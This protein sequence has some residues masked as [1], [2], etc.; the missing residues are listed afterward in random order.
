MD[1]D[2]PK[3][4]E[5]E[6]AALMA[7]STTVRK[8]RLEVGPTI[9]PKRRKQLKDL[10]V[11]VSAD[12][13]C[14][15]E[16]EQNFAA[17]YFNKLKEQL[18]PA[19]F[20]KVLELLSDFDG[21]SEGVINLF[22]DISSL[23]PPSLAKEFLCF[24]TPD[25]AHLC[26]KFMD[27]FILSKMIEFFRKFEICF[28]KQPQMVRKFYDVLCQ[29]A[30]SEDVSL[31]QVREA[32][33]PLLKTKNFLMEYFLQLFP[34]EKPSDSFVLDDY[35][36]IYLDGECGVEEE[37]RL[38]ETEESANCPCSCHPSHATH[39]QRCAVKYINGRVYIQTGKVLRSARV[40]FN[41][42]NP[43][44][45]LRRVCVNSEELTPKAKPIRRK[46]DVHNQKDLSP[47]KHVSSPH[48]A[49]T[50]SEDESLEVRT[51]NGTNNKPKSAR[52][53]KIKFKSSEKLL[54]KVKN[55]RTQEG[56]EELKIMSDENAITDLPDCFLARR[57]SPSE[58]SEL[59]NLNFNNILSD[60]QNEYSKHT[61]SESVFNFSVHSPLRRASICLEGFDS[62]SE[63]AQSPI[64]MD[65]RL[66]IPLKRID[67]DDSLMTIHNKDNHNISVETM[68][69][70]SDRSGSEIF[71]P[72]TP[73]K[74]DVSGTV[75]TILTSSDVDEMNVFIS[76]SNIDKIN[77][78]GVSHFEA[79]KSS[80]KC[81]DKYS[82][83]TM[84]SMS[85]DSFLNISNLDAKIDSFLTNAEGANNLDALLN[86]SSPESSNMEKNT[87]TKESTSLHQ[88]EID[89]NY[90]ADIKSS[91]NLSPVPKVVRNMDSILD[92]IDQNVS[93]SRNPSILN[94]SSE[95]VR[96]FQLPKGEVPEKVEMSPKKEEILDEDQKSSVLSTTSDAQNFKPVKVRSMDS[97]LEFVEQNVPA[98]SNISNLNIFK[99]EDETPHFENVDSQQ[100]DK[101]APQTNL[102]VRSV[103]PLKDNKSVKEEVKVEVL[104]ITFEPKSPLKICDALQS[105]LISD[106]KEEAPDTKIIS[107]I[108]ES[109]SLQKCS[110]NEATP[111]DIDQGLL[112]PKSENGSVQEE[113]EEVSPTFAAL[114]AAKECSILEPK[115]EQVDSQD[116]APILDN[117]RVESETQADANQALLSPKTEVKEEMQEELQEASQMTSADVFGSFKPKVEVVDSESNGVDFSATESLDTAKVRCQLLETPLIVNQSE[118]VQSVSFIYGEGGDE[119]LKVTLFSADPVEEKAIDT[120]ILSISTDSAT[121]ETFS[122]QILP[123]NGASVK[124]INKSLPTTIVEKL[125]EDNNAAILG[126]SE[127]INEPTSVNFSQKEEN[128]ISS[129]S[130]VEKV[131]RNNFSSLRDLL[132]KDQFNQEISSFVCKRTEKLPTASSF[133][134]SFTS[135]IDKIEDPSTTH[136]TIVSNKE[137]SLPHVARGSSKDCQKRSHLKLSDSTPVRSSV[138]IQNS[139]EALPVELA[140][141]QKNGRGIVI[142][143]SGSAVKLTEGHGNDSLTDSSQELPEVQKCDELVSPDCSK[144][145]ETNAENIEKLMSSEHQSQLVDNHLKKEDSVNLSDYVGSKAKDQGNDWTMEEDKIILQTFQKDPDMQ[146]IFSKIQ[147]QL[148]ERSLQEVQSRFYVLI[149]LLEKMSHSSEDAS[150]KE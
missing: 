18:E 69:T 119:N 98:H 135:N 33:L 25:Q 26:G 62:T 74:S 108:K 11:L 65:Q 77:V 106:V 43:V 37:I 38:A 17:N 3:D 104:D 34:S 92:L 123:H 7:A 20:V 90:V 112:S 54:A 88:S 76:S 57:L 91:M 136:L 6:L 8:R 67:D 134:S 129:S 132:I 39:C 147:T 130:E 133:P 5:D 72:D 81:A 107:N 29:L 24:L 94:G 148:P 27:H 13:A 35:E 40:E 23:L 137:R 70:S 71:K 83:P 41:G 14:Q 125:S 19:V 60:N 32:V 79:A 50:E 128:I 138:D 121:G 89:K 110:I 97:I 30:S 141:S 120:D 75:D 118:A 63:S 80:Q 95:K 85:I 16:R 113:A 15:K 48:M 114:S 124:I 116:S 131:P 28:A 58:S 46:P 68:N 99:N 1:I 139:A 84:D 127:V 111:V 109:Q 49:T 36:D 12:D 117:S 9:N 87:D 149:E 96:D 51:I 142:S 115:K 55:P 4:D 42:F 73:M 150:K 66:C 122:R 143:T 52:S 59:S 10:A 21:T 145:Q 103:S 101:E 86:D 64:K 140:E 102:E 78:F 105:K 146:D 47:I 22:Q 31:Q 2:E 144:K 53:L 56:S 45:A 100:L 126:R 82:E 61:D 93:E 44:D